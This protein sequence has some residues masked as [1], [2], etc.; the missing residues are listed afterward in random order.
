M[1]QFIARLLWVAACNEWHK[2]PWSR[3]S[4]YTRGLI[5]LGCV[6][7]DEPYPTHMSNGPVERFVLIRLTPKELVDE[8]VDPVCSVDNLMEFEG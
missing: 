6:A 2:P 1:S 3:S 8:L 7:R 5:A 4:D